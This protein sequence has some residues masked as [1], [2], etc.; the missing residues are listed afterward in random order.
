MSN[1]PMIQ[2]PMYYCDCETF[3]MKDLC[4]FGEYVH[5]L[6]SLSVCDELPVGCSPHKNQILGAWVILI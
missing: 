2:K 4:V 6:R 3:Q 5:K 1:G